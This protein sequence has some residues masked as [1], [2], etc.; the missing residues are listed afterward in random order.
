MKLYYYPGACSQ[1]V[2][3]ALRESG[4]PFEIEKIDLRVGKTERGADYRAINPK[5]YVPALELDNGEV[6]TEVV[7]L[8]QYVADRR[9]ESLLAPPWGN[10]ERYRLVEWL[11][12]ISS[13]L[14]KQF[15]PFFKGATD[16]VKRQQAE[17]ITRRFEYIDRRLAST[18]FLMGDTFTVA[19]A[20]LFVMSGWA[21]MFQIDT[22]RFPALTAWIKRVAS[23]PAVGEVLVTEGLVKK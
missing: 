21:K 7:A 9:P 18:S 8:L 22:E 10:F 3:I 11:A 4:L 20:Y 2:H 6:L 15:G 13:E 14:H 16:E 12:F 19:D 1:A 23:R 5:G 17:L